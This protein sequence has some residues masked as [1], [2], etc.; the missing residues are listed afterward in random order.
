MKRQR[1]EE[2]PDLEPNSQGSQN[3]NGVLRAEDLVQPGPSGES[4]AE[5]QEEREASSGS[6]Y[7]P[8]S[9][10]SSSYHSCV[11]SLSDSE[12]YPFS[13]S[14][15]HVETITAENIAWDPDTKLESIPKRSRIYSTEAWQG[16]TLDSSPQ[17]VS[18]LGLL[19][20][21]EATL[22]KNNQELMEEKAGTSRDTEKRPELPDWT[23]PSEDAYCCLTCF[24]IFSTHGALEAHR[25][26]EVREGFGCSIFHHPIQDRRITLQ[27]G[28][29][30]EDLRRLYQEFQ[31]E[32]Q[33]DHA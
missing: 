29:Q 30:N 32:H 11:S 18:S 26:H 28:G 7:S 27:N 6:L 14:Y 9:S 25:H 13:F 19:I 5:R 21:K 3:S 20:G 16:S 12:D 23:N 24:R 17:N 4:R 15:F 33:E 1:E 2:W 22:E 8:L 10:S 31:P